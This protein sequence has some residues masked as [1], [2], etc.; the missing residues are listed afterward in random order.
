MAGKPNAGVFDSSNLNLY[1]YTFQNPVKY[2][3]PTGLSI[4]SKVDYGRFDRHLVGPPRR[5]RPTYTLPLEGR[6]I[7][8]RKAGFAFL[9]YGGKYG[10]SRRLGS[11]FHSG[12]DILAPVGSRVLAAGKG[13]VVRTTYHNKAGKYVTIAYKKGKKTYYVRYLHLSLINVKVGDT[14]QEGEIIGWT[15]KTG[16]ARGLP[17]SQ[18]HLHMDVYLKV[19][20]RRKYVDPHDLFGKAGS[21]DSEGRTIPQMSLTK[22][23]KTAI[24]NYAAGRAAARAAAAAT[25]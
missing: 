5:R 14:V 25:R 6:N 13:E 19:G 21:K 16:N 3:D 17:R 4:R 18:D 7:V 12:A 10:Y 1:A 9:P 2:I 23:D 8:I 24:R 22:A 20:R 11:K 15:G